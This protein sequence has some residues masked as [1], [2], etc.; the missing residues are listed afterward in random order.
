M[1]IIVPVQ[2][3]QTCVLEPDD[4]HIGLKHVARKKTVNCE[5][6]KVTDKYQQELSKAVTRHRMAWQSRNE[7][8]FLSS[9]ILY[10]LHRNVENFFSDEPNKMAS[11]FFLLWTIQPSIG[12]QTF[13]T[14]Q[15]LMFQYGS[16]ISSIRSSDVSH[17]GL[18]TIL[19]WISVSEERLFCQMHSF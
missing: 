7:G 15:Q 9:S 13:N 3:L 14:N 4:G 10:W 18:L 11:T 1:N 17:C 12:T 2:W 6:V 16:V 5:C 8:T 19:C